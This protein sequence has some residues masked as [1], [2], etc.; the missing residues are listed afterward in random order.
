MLRK[1]EGVT[2][3]KR[4][5]F[6]IDERKRLQRLE[7][8]EM[9]EAEMAEE[10]ELAMRGFGILLVARSKDLFTVKPEPRGVAGA[11]DTPRTIGRGRGRRR[12]KLEVID[13]SV[14]TLCT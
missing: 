7:E 13:S 2:P 3:A 11:L 10:E 6:R 14:Q 1:I 5:Q 8:E 4:K 12:E 9:A